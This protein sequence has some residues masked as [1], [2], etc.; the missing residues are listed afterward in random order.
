MIMI[1]FSKKAVKNYR[2]SKCLIIADYRCVNY[3]NE[4]ETLQS[5]LADTYNIDFY[6]IITLSRFVIQLLLKYFGNYDVWIVDKSLMVE[7]SKNISFLENL[8]YSY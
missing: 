8:S 2:N 4:C 6:P 7:I 1:E 5:R 3:E